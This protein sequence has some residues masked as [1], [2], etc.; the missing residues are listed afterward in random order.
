MEMKLQGGVRTT[1]KMQR[2]GHGNQESAGQSDA[3]ARV[4]TN[5]G[6]SRNK[7]AG[8]S[9]GIYACISPVTHQQSTLRKCLTLCR[10]LQ[11]EKNIAEVSLEATDRITTT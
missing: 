8:Y 10:F 3:K 9:L 11:E 5:M 6:Q 2:A 7:G 4:T 1:A